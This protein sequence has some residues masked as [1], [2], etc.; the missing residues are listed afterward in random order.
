MCT[1]YTTH[2]AVFGQ[3][4]WARHQDLLDYISLK[5]LLSSCRT[6]ISSLI[7]HSLISFTANMKGICISSFFAI[8][9][10]LVQRAVA[11]NIPNRMAACSSHISTAS[12]DNAT[13][14]LFYYLTRQFA[15]SGSVIAGF[16]SIMDI[17]ILSSNTNLRACFPFKD[18]QHCL[19]SQNV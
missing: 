14:N 1:W 5:Y 10:M 3:N 2:V 4:I 15:P 12:A 13:S 7:P 11:V 6:T 17:P 18:F 16:D 8:G 9:A 19:A